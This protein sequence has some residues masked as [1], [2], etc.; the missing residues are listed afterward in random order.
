MH[1]GRVRLDGFTLIELLVVIAIIGILASLLLPALSRAKERARQIAC[2]SLI[3]QYGRANFLYA[4]DQDGRFVFTAYG[5]TTPHGYSIYWLT[6][7]AYLEYLGTSMSVVSNGENG[8]TGAAGWGARLPAQLRCPSAKIMP[9]CAWQHIVSYGYNHRSYMS[10]ANYTVVNVRKPSER[11][12]FAESQSW[13]IVK[14][15]ADITK[16]MTYGEFDDWFDG[17][18]SSY[19]WS[20]YTLYRHDNGTNVAFF[21]GHAEYRRMEDVW[22]PGDTAARNEM[23]DAWNF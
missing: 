17:S 23:W 5:G 18:G 21:D 11:L 7:D 8:L 15:G 19:P 16:W 9:N 22:F 6:C 3:N 2:L 20:G 14:G 1:A 10:R 13:W 4:D 12:M